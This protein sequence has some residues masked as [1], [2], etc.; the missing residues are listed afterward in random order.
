[1]KPVHASVLAL[2]IVLLAACGDQ[3][4]GDRPAAPTPDAPSVATP[5]SEEAMPK[6]PESPS[7]EPAIR[8]EDLAAHLK[9][10]A[11]DEFG[12]RQPGT[13]G[14]RKTVAYLE[15]E[16]ARIG[17]APGNGDRYRQAVPM[18]EIHS[19]P[20]GPLEVRLPDG[21]TETLAFSSDVVFQSLRED[22]EVAVVDSELVFVGFG[23]NAP[24]LGWNDY[25][26]VDVVGK[27]VLVLVNDPGFETGDET[28]FRGPAMTYYGR[29]TYKYEEALRQGAAAALVVHDDLGAAY[30]WDVVQNSFTGTEFD[31]PQPA[32]RPKLAI[33][34]WITTPATERLLARL[35]R[36]LKALRAAANQPGFR[37]IPL[38]ATASMGVRNRVRHAQSQNVLGLVRGSERPQEVIVFTAHWDHLG[39]TFN[40]KDDGIFN[41]AIDNA[42]GLATLLETA[43]AIA[44]GATPQRSV[45]FLAVTLEESGLLGSRYYVENPVYPLRDTVAVINVDAM[46][47]IG[48]TRDVVVIG[49]GHSELEDIL[50][51]HAAAQ[52][53]IVV[54]E[55][56]PEKGFYYRS[57]H[58][59][60]ARA[61]VPALYPKNGI[62]HVEKGSEFGRQ[63]SADYILKDYHKPSDEFREDWD[64]SGLVQDTELIHAVVRDLADSARWP[65]WYEG[66][67]FRAI[68]EAMGR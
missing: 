49:Y 56:T 58:F 15:R 10:L 47:I 4:A 46:Q 52:G 16:F 66:S 60:F 59:N 55:P 54:G 45:L 39:R 41:G 23:V 2:T 20:R 28:L 68:R 33:R 44:R 36:D 42:T 62:D 5:A 22:P 3:P 64:L 51:D 12:G 6:L 1:M 53:R 14:E 18:V 13:A 43:E 32:D 57:D 9:I 24:E 48:P 34:G 30:G 31:L 25:E 35:G 40:A 67:E 27:T 63:V 26:G 17:L 21:N 37:A 50:R 11:S 19:E 8:S 29:W 38:G 65:K 61:G 7:T